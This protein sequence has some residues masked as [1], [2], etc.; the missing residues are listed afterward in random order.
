MAFF[1][2]LA[3]TL[4]PIATF[5]TVGL[6]PSGKVIGLPLGRKVKGLFAEGEG[7]NDPFPQATAAGFDPMLFEA[8]T[9]QR[10]IPRAVLPPGPPPDIAGLFAPVRARVAPQIQEQFIPLRQRAVG[11]LRDIGALGTPAQEKVLGGLDVQQSKAIA[12]ALSDLTQQEAGLKLQ[13]DQAERAR[14][15]Q[16]AI[17]QRDLEQSAEEARLNRLQQLLLGKLSAEE[18]ATLMNI[19]SAT[20]LREAQEARRRSREAGLFGLGGGAIGGFAQQL[21]AKGA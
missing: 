11:R 9:R 2:K 6:S 10:E 21:F 13:F 12:T 8:V 20:R 19:E 7:P 4:L 5:G 15:T 14:Q 17:S 3:K 1:K 16:E 18:R